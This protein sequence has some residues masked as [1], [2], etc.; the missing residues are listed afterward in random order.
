M[1]LASLF[2]IYILVG[3]VHIVI[4]NRGL[5]HHEDLDL[6]HVLVIHD[7]K[8]ILDQDQEVL[9]TREGELLTNSFTYSS[10][11]KKNQFCCVIYIETYNYGLFT[12]DLHHIKDAEDI[13]EAG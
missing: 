10:L 7:Q 11:H 8:N 9:T 6:V 2:Q 5:I 12:I 13:M 4:Q 3:L 1:Y